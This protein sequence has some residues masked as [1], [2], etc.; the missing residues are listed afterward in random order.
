MLNRIVGL[1]VIKTRFDTCVIIYALAL[2]AIMRGSAYLQV[3][4]GVGGKLLYAACLG[5]VLMAGAK[6]FDATRP[7]TVPRRR[8]TD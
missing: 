5:A 4:P 6:L 2:G 8:W 1:L 7:V 3:Y